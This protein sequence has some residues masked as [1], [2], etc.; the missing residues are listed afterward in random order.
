MKQ[1]DKSQ[2]EK[3]NLT[4]SEEALRQIEVRLM[5]ECEFSDLPFR[6]HI[7][8]KGCDGFT[9][10]TGFTP[11]HDDDFVFL[12]KGPIVGTDIKVVIEPFTAFYCRTAEIDYFLDEEFEEE[13]FVVNVSE[14]ENFHGK[15][16]T[17]EEYQAPPT[18][19]FH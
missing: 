1:I 6:L 8:G 3:P 12:F 14:Q 17:K 18:L 10:S 13:G 11:K 7:K 15:F 19:D 2:I 16:F 5:N 9:Y 4:L